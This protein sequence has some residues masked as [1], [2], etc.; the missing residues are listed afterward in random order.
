M[1]CLDK[2]G[3]TELKLTAVFTPAKYSVTLDPN[4]GSFNK[5]DR[6]TDREGTH[7]I[8]NYAEPLTEHCEYDVSYQTPIPERKE[9]ENAYTF[10]GWALSPDGDVKYKKGSDEKIFFSN[11]ADGTALYAVWAADAIPVYTAS[12]DPGNNGKWKEDYF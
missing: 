5:G 6:Y 7:T 3:R 10:R 11:L 12:V 8:T 9:G 2:A 1:K 4:G